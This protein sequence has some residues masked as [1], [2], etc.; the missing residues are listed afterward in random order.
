MARVY[1]GL[2][3]VGAWALTTAAAVTLTLSLGLIVPKLVIDQLA[4]GR[5][6]P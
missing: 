1:R 6:R 5:A 3:H 2:L 4:D